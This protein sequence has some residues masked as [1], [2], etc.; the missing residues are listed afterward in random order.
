MLVGLHPSQVVRVLSIHTSL[1]EWIGQHKS[2][3]RISHQNGQNGP[4]PKSMKSEKGTQEPRTSKSLQA[5]G[6]PIWIQIIRLQQIGGHLNT[7]TSPDAKARKLVLSGSTTR[8]LNMGG[9]FWGGPPTWLRRSDVASLSKHP[10]W[11]FSKKQAKCLQE[12]CKQKA[13]RKPRLSSEMSP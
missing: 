6:L 5:S 4:S 3:L 8:M 12:V 11:N 10:K 7:P 13:K 9:L 2:E 1:P